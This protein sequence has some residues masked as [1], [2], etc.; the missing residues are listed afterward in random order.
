MLVSVTVPSLSELRSIALPS[1]Y[2]FSVE[3]R[4]ARRHWDRRM[5]VAKVVLLVVVC[6]NGWFCAF[7]DE[8]PP[9]VKF[10][11]MPYPPRSRVRPLPLMSYANPNRGPKSRFE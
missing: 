10:Q 1:V 3:K 6:R 9:G 8:V 4:F 11:K 5:L 7:D 2:E